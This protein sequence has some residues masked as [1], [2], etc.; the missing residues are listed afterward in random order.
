[1]QPKTMSWA[2]FLPPASLSDKKEDSKSC[3]KRRS[4]CVILS[5]ANQGPP[6]KESS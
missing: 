4:S 6:E 1:M 5:Q 2:S 3:P